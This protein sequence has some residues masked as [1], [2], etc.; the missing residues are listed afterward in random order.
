MSAPQRI[1]RRRTKGWRMPEGAKYVGR[2]TK[3]GN[4]FVVGKTQVR[5]PALDGAEWE[6]EDRLHKVSGQK[7]FFCTGTDE[8]GMPVGIWH[9]VEDAT[10]E[11]CVELYRRRWIHL[12]DLDALRAEL[13]GLDLACW[14]PLDRPCHADVLLTLAN[15]GES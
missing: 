6:H 12:A 3:W 14:C 10:P 8:R 5:I 11:Q 1:Q 4:P 2:G 13:A 15:G 9:Q 7:N